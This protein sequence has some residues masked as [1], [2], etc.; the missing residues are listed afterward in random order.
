MLCQAFLLVS[1]YIPTRVVVT[2][3]RAV[4]IL[5]T[6]KLRLRD[7]KALAQGHTATR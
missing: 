3:G 5:Q 4:F 2:R 7:L 1:C 6:R